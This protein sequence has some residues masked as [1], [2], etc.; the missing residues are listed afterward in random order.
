M[1]GAD[2]SCDQCISGHDNLCQNSQ[3]TCLGHEGGYAT[4]ARADSRLAFNIPDALPSEYAAPLL[5]AGITVCAP[6]IRHQVSGNARL[7]VTGIGGLGH[8]AIQ[9]GRALG[10]HVIA[11]STSS[12]KEAEAIQFGAS[13]F[14]DTS[15]SGALA[16]RANSYDFILCT[17]TADLPWIEYITALRPGGKLCVVGVPE[18]EMRVSALALV[19]GQ[20]SVIASIVGSRSDMKAMLEFSARHNIVPLI[21]KYKMSEVNDALQRIAKNEVRYRAVLEME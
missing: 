8:L 6:L 13:D 21:E 10:C 9:Y 11:F 14:V 20:K 18:S 7:G 12:D 5:C 1:S 19:F 17:A 16:T 2:F 15:Q 3:P 4:H